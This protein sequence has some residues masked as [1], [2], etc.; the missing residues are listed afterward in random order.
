MKPERC[1]G[2]G[3]I[4]KK[5]KMETKPKEYTTNRMMMK[6]TNITTRKEQED[7]TIT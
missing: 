3:T 4:R 7:R 5:L 2:E 6:Y 1:K